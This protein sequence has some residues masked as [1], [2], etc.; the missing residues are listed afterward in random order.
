M[1]LNNKAKLVQIAKSVCR[2]LRKNQTEAEKIFWQAVRN[3]KFCGKKFYR[4]YPIFHDITGKET[5]FVADFYCY[6][7]KLVV[8]LDGKIH[9]YRLI[10]D[11]V[12]KEFINHLGIKVVRFKND[13]I[14]N[15]LSKLLDEVKK[16][17]DSY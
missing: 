1:S 6:E 17:L 7:A 12:R 16:H 8:E 4:Q 2:E 11:S 10:E 5:F 13:E 15:N 14:V 3:R 9:Q